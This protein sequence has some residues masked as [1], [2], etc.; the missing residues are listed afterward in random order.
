MITQRTRIKP[1]SDREVKRNREYQR[2]KRQWRALPENQRCAYPGCKRPAST[3][4]HHARGRVGSLKC[5]VRW[6]VPICRP[7]HDWVHRNIAEA[8]KLGLICQLGEWG[9]TE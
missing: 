7:H 1:I 4:P 3:A 8:R 2:V 5:D 9:K 6:F